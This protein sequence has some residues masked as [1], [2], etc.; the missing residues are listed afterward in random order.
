MQESFQRLALAQRGTPRRWQVSP[1]AAPTSDFMWRSRYFV[2]SHRVTDEYFT[3][4]GED[5][6]RQ[7]KQRLVLAAIGYG[8]FLHESSQRAHKDKAHFG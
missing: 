3:K 2:V 1:G 8:R 4:R 6:Y 5:Q 7:V